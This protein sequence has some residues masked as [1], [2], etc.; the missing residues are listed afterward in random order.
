MPDHNQRA[1]ENVNDTPGMAFS[2]IPYIPAD[3]ALSKSTSRMRLL[4]VSAF[5]AASVIGMVAAY[6]FLPTNH[7]D[8]NAPRVVVE[9]SGMHCPIQCGLRVSAA[10]ERLPFVLPGT[11]TANPE[12]GAGSSRS[13]LLVAKPWPKTRFAWPLRR[14]GSGSDPSRR[15]T[16]F[17]IRTGVMPELHTMSNRTP[18]RADPRCRTCP[19]P[20]NAVSATYGVAFQM[21]KHTDTHRVVEPP[22]DAPD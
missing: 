14:S 15:P 16:L 17:R 1:A 18:F 19:D 4:V 3:S 6:L 7:D 5:V 13:Q 21:G 8:P 12:T 9:V 22:G 20:A 2:Q 10:L 11:V